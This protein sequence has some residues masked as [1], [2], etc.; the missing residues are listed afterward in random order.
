MQPPTPL[1]IANPNPCKIP[2]PTLTLTL[3]LTLTQGVANLPAAMCLASSSVLTA[4]F[5]V[6][7]GKMMS[8][9]SLTRV[10][11]V[12]L[13]VM[14]PLIAF[15]HIIKGVSSETSTPNATSEAD[16]LMIDRHRTEMREPPQGQVAS[17]LRTLSLYSRPSAP[18]PET[19]EAGLLF[20]RE[21]INF[22]FA[23]AF[24]G[25]ASGL[26]GITKL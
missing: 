7:V 21:N 9:R 26:L 22:V 15:K 5:G 4:G 10:V 24:T 23:G 25:F 18:F 2:T 16:T 11:G 13:L 3:T 19:P 20:I 17:F 8:D 6:R 1:R 12:S 14:S